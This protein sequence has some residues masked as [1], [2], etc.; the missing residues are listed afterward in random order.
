MPSKVTKSRSVCPSAAPASARSATMSAR[1][2]RVV[3]ILASER[4]NARALRRVFDG[5]SGLRHLCP[6]R[7]GIL[8]SPLRARLL[9][10]GHQFRHRCRNVLGGRL[11]FGKPESKDLIGAE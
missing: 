2:D 10:C 3:P 6:E 7:V 9:S 1:T 4:P 5:E 8:P 11:P